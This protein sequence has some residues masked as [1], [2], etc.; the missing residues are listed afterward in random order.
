MPE[1]NPKPIEASELAAKKPE[2]TTFAEL[3]S[4]VWI[5]NC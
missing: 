1:A 4:I 2:D 3:V 5:S